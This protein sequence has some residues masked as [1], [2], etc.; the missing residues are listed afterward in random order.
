MTTIFEVFRD[1]KN[2]W[3]ARRDDGRVE[4]VF[5]DRVSAIRFARWEGP[6]Q[7]ATAWG[8]VQQCNRQQLPPL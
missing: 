5:V 3:H 2:F 7:T 4:G 6:S 8:S 1:E